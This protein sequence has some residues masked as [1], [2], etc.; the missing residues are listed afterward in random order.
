MTPQPLLVTG[1]PRSGTTWLARLLAGADRTSMLGREPMN[2]RPGQYRLART[3]DG[4]T[5]LTAPSRLQRTVLQLAYL[6]LDPLVYGRFGR[7]QLRAVL[8]T[9]R[10]VVKDPFAMLSLATVSGVTGC[11]PILVYR[12]PA[13]VLAS[14][15]RMGWTADVSEVRRV[16]AA[17]AREALGDEPW[18][19]PGL[20]GDAAAMCWFWS[21]LHWH[22]LAD[23]ASVPDAV[24]VCHEELSEAGPAAA[25]V[26]FE[27]CG[28]AW[29]D[30]TQAH[31]VAA[32]AAAGSETSDPASLHTNLTRRPADV[33]GSW[34]SRMSP[35]ERAAVE[36]ATESVAERLDARRL[37]VA[38]PTATPPPS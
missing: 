19:L 25:R 8:P 11:R 6:G 5:R 4:W 30:S 2:P 7:G 3:V 26:L 27:R 23:L 28:V 1:V 17:G 32:F 24:V 13:A 18:D 20:T 35:G 22:A 15:R 9:T 10:I 14:Y 21:V 12:H 31:V 16:M 37:R 33:A 36:A 29:T 34:R 38:A